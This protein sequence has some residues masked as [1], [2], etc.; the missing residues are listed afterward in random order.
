MKTIDKNEL[1]VLSAATQTV[2]LKDSNKHY[3]AVTDAVLA[4]KTED[5]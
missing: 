2:L 5:I 3:I 4:E 1:I